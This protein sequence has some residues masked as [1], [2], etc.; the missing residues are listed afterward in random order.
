ME[1]SKYKIKRDKSFTLKDLPEEERPRERLLKFGSESLSIQ[2]LL[3]IILRSGSRGESVS[4]L[5]QKLLSHFGNLNKLLEASI[6]ELMEVKGVGLAKA[7]QIKAVYEIVRRYNSYIEKS[8]ELKKIMS[9]QDVFK[10]VKGKL[11]DYKKEHFYIVALNTRNQVISE[12]SVGTLN[13]SL[14]HPREVF[15]EAIKSR[16][17]SIILVHNHPSGDLTPSEDDL[18]ITKTLIEGGKIL[19]IEILDH[20]IISE[21]SYF[22]FKSKGLI[23]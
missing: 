11:K 22:S 10:F 6:E 19:N 4:N 21:N 7:A 20:I 9:P 23:K 12:I 8:K 3:Q 1:N 17:N 18:K 14:V 5:S 2:E 13:A 16:A 15:A